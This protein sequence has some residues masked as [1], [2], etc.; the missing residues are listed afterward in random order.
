MLDAMSDKKMSN[1]FEC[2]EPLTSAGN[3]NAQ[4]SPQGPLAGRDP[5]DA[6]IDISG[7]FSLAGQKWNALK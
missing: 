5:N 1:V 2:T 3:P 6:G 7:L 4:A